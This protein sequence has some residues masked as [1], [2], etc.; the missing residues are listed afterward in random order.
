MSSTGKPT[1]IPDFELN[2][3]GAEPSLLARIGRKGLLKQLTGLR[4]GEL[5]LVDLDGT[6][7]RFGALLQHFRPE[8]GVTGGQ[9]LVWVFFVST[10]FL[11]HGTLFINSLAHAFGRVRYKTTDDSR[12]S[13]LIAI[14]TL[15]EGWHNNHHHYQRSERQGFYWWELDITHYVLRVFSLFGLVRDLH[16]PPKAIRDAR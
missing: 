12:N 3:E 1:I 14:F 11:P 9:M 7:H 5:R 15:G 8:L 6:Q 4:D 10:T 13:F 16:A 2:A